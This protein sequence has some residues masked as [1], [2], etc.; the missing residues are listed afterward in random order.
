MYKLFS[1]TI[2]LV[3]SLVPLGPLPH[4]PIMNFVLLATVL[5]VGACYAII[6]REN[7]VVNHGH[8]F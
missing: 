8:L 3:P 7:N 6:K 1:G 2:Q 5:D 4:K